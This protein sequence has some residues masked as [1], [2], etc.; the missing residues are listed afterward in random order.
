[1]KDALRGLL[2]AFPDMHW[3]VHEQIAEGDKVVSRFEWTGTHR[4]L[5]LGVPATDQTVTV[6]GMVIDR[7]DGGKI[8]DTRII[9]DTLGLMM[10]L[11]VVP[12]P[13]G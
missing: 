11:G 9:M 2:E 5:F 4:G 6:W 1:M 7:L 8:K 13:Q 3:T 10:Q 12:P